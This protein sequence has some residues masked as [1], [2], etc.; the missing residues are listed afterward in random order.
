[1]RIDLGDYF[2]LFLKIAEVANYFYKKNEIDTMSIIVDAGY[3]M[4]I[5]WIDVSNFL[6]K[7]LEFIYF[8][9]HLMRIKVEVQNERL[10]SNG[11]MPL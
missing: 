10:T 9:V 2:R 7:N 11:K 8:L 6:S 1:L 5:L 3:S 4:S